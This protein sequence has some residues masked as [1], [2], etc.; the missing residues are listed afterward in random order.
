MINDEVWLKEQAQIIWAE[1]EYKGD[2]HKALRAAIFEAVED[3]SP[4]AALSIKEP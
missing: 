3:L 2:G 1:V 4:H